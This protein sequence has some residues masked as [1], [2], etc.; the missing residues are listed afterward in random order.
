MHGP[1][2]NDPAFDQ[3]VG[4]M[5]FGP[6]AL[7]DLNADMLRWFDYWLRGE[8]NGVMD[9]PPV[10][11]FLMGA[12]RWRTADSWPPAAAKP[13]RLYFARGTGRST[14]SMNNGRLV[15]DKPTGAQPADSYVYDPRDPV[16][17]IGGNTLHSPPLPAGRTG[18]LVAD[19][20]AAAGPR[21]QSSIEGRCLTYTTEPLAEDLEVVGPVE[22]VLHVSSSAPDTDFVAKLCDVF[23]DGRSI[24]VADGIL[25]SRYR[26]S[27][28]RP[29][30]LDPGKVYELEIDL[31]STAWLFPAGHQL[32]VTVTSSCFPRFDR[33]PNTGRAMAD[34]TEVRSATN[35][36]FHDARRKS[37]VVLSVMKTD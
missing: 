5:D 1:T 25:R 10:R 4:E 23:P 2:L 12:N 14:S 3:R 27:R 6:G 35:R 21:D 20:M 11:Y 8:P 22:V 15:L 37:H 28:S 34:S 17:S 36:V 29:R 26:E 24:Q 19:F 16:P 31:W 9:A 30:P 7:M 32:R 18:P 13:L 33:N